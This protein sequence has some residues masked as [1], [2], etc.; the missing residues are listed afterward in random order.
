MQLKVR[1][2]IDVDFLKKI[3]GDDSAFEKELF[4]IFLDN[5]RYNLSKIENAMISGDSNAWY[6]ASH[7]FKGSSSSIGAFELAQ[8]L[9]NSQK[10]SDSDIEIKHEIFQATRQEFKKVEEFILKR[11]KNF[12]I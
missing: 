7:A 2:P 4:E 6:M 12:S 5:S 10:N 3:I 1:D 8:A 11:L 9:E